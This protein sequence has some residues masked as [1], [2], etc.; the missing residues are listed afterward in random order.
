M[1]FFCLNFRDRRCDSWLTCSLTKVLL[2]STLLKNSYD[3]FSASSSIALK[4][5]LYKH[6]VR[7]FKQKQIGESSG[8]T[9]S[10]KEKLQM[11]S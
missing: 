10:N 6:T 5:L 3:R 1:K 7:E 4:H 8:V 2:L 11:Y 9:E